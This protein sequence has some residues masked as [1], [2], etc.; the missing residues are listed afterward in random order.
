[1]RK[2]L[3]SLLIILLPGAPSIAQQVNQQALDKL[4]NEAR[5]AHSDGL[6][7]YKDGELLGEWYF[8][9]EPQKVDIKSVT[10]S[11]AS[12]GYGILV[13][14]EKLKIDQ[15]VADFY[16]EWNQ[17]N[18]QDIT[19]RHLLTHTS[20][21]LD[22][23]FGL[24]ETTHDI[25]Q[26]S[27][28]SDL[29]HPVGKHYVY[30]N[31]A[32]NLLA[33][34]AEKADGRKLDVMIQEELFGPL[35]ISD[36]TW[37]KDGKRNPYVMAFL[38]MKPKDL[39]KIGLFVLNK[40]TWEGQRI[41]DE[42]WFEESMKPGAEFLPEY[43][44]LWELIR[45]DFRFVVDDQQIEMMKQA[46]VDLKLVAKAEEMKGMY[47]GYGEY[48]GT[49]SRTFGRGWGSWFL[50]EL[51][52]YGL[53]IGRKEAGAQLGFMG[54]GYLGQYLV[55]YPQ[56]D[57]V[58]VRMIEEFEGYSWDTDEFNQFPELLRKLAQ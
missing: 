21:L 4:V 52:P 54:M 34:I 22:S 12:L 46:G 32:V 10:K 18:K 42:N 49:I 28:A 56:H 37:P 48:F 27:L 20:G 31:K 40:G 33:G 23:D 29:T 47:H 1:M 9:K 24:V 25:V 19:I 2:N 30:N 50:K 6:V 14:Q 35:G 43:G 39:A 44:L 55:I 45:K 11:L 53:E 26:F 17:E 8:S 7:I 36:I 58:G 41:I 51:A 15:P 16:P 57:L 38:Q 5:K 3:L 13:S